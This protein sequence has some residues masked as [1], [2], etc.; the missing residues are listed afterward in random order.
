MIL[1]RGHLQVEFSYFLG[2]PV[3]CC[4]IFPISNPVFLFRFRRIEGAP[5][6]CCIPPKRRLPCRSSPSGFSDRNNPVAHSKAVFD[7]F[8][9]YIKKASIVL[10]LSKRLKYVC[11]YVK[12]SRI[13]GQPK[14]IRIN[15]FNVVCK[16][17]LILNCYS[18]THFRAS[19]I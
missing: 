19:C 4:Q 17:I 15:S 12:T 3:Q 16:H 10:L 5:G 2:Y 14:I 7:T 13:P 18:R 9:W 11:K 6:W 1:I 8:L